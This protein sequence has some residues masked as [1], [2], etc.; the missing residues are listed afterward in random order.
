MIRA[1]FIPQVLA[2]GSRPLIVFRKG[3][4][5]FHAVAA[6]ET[7]IALVTLDSLRGLRELTRHGE[8]YPAK[9]CASYW[10]NKDYR[11]IAKRAKAVLRG[12]VARKPRQGSAS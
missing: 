6:R 5:K 4:T 10:L 2:N 8:P 12:I 9:R 11:P 1:P 3:R 7:D